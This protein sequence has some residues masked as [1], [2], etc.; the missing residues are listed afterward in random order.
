MG[1]LDDVREPSPWTYVG[2]VGAEAAKFTPRGEQ[3]VRTLIQQILGPPG[4]VLV[5][6][7]CPLGGVDIWAEQEYALLRTLNLEERPAPVIHHPREPNWS[8]GFQPRNRLIARD[9]AILH[10]IVVDRY[11][12]GYGGR[13]WD[14]EGGTPLCYHCERRKRERKLLT[15]QAHVKSGGCWTAIEAEKLGKEVQWHIVK[16]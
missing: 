12:T 13:R 8:K 2:I 3:A 15:Y 7:G 16:Q 10:N 14:R 5:S 6:G 1:L 4:R 9:S 11:I